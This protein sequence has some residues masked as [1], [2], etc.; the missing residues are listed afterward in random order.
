M[1]DLQIYIKTKVES[2]EKLTSNSNYFK[3]CAEYQFQF[4]RCF[5]WFISNPYGLLFFMSVPIQD[6]EFL[7]A[8]IFTSEKTKKM[9]KGM[10]KIFVSQNTKGK[11]EKEVRKG[12][13][14][15]LNVGKNHFGETVSIKETPTNTKDVFF[16]EKTMN[17]LKNSDAVYFADGWQQS[18]KCRLEKMVA[19]ANSVMIL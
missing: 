18:G 19:L 17:A 7:K 4:S 15:A 16:L 14:E 5:E 2:R 8:S 11:T 9:E 13:M 12:E 10:K 6:K 1:V 3:L